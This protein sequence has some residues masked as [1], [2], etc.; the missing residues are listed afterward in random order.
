M[1]PQPAIKPSRKKREQSPDFQNRFWNKLK[2]SRDWVNRFWP[3]ALLVLF[4]GCTPALVEKKGN[5][6]PVSVASITPRL[7]K[8]SLAAATT[9]KFISTV[10]NALAGANHFYELHFTTLATPLTPPAELGN[11]YMA[12]PLNYYPLNRDN[13][14]GVG[15]DK[16]PKNIYVSHDLV[17]W[18][19][20]TSNPITSA[21]F[22]T[23]NAPVCFFR[24]GGSQPANVT[25]EKL[26]NIT[27]IN[28]A[29]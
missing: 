25:P 29:F 10:T 5:P 7:A 28:R 16:R 13:L 6:S 23:D 11:G 8:S 14:E 21:F 3:A 15:F 18:T 24:V 4:V 22:W 20:A 19:L 12:D 9:K 2:G 27:L 1:T 26:C 17:T